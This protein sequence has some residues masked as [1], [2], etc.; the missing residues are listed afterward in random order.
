MT[1]LLMWQPD[2][3]FQ[4]RPYSILIVI[5]LLVPPHGKIIVSPLFHMWGYNKF[6]FRERTCFV[7]LTFK[8]VA[9]PPVC[10]VRWDFDIILTANLPRNLPLEKILKFVKNWQNCGHESVF[11]PTRYISRFQRSPCYNVFLNG[12]SNTQNCL[13]SCGDPG[14][15]LIRSPLGTPKSTTQTASRSVLP[16][17]QGSGLWPTDS[18]IHRQTSELATNAAQWQL[19]FLFYFSCSATVAASVYLYFWYHESRQ[20]VCRHWCMSLKLI[21]I[22]CVAKCSS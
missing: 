19:S 16:F 14:P 4:C 10:K 9:P 13:F 21:P 15:H 22:Y 5:C 8:I 18:H 17:L 1:Y 6:F 2:S 11:W 7:P 12:R 3:K 20:S